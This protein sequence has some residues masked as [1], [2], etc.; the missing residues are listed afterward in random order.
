MTNNAAATIKQGKIF[1][2]ESEN[3]SVTT[4]A[5]L[6]R[7]ITPKT[8]CARNKSNSGVTFS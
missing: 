1:I 2:R 7:R 5:F 3:K 8:G 4:L 6:F